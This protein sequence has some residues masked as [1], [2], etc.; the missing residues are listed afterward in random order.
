MNSY[1][2]L[3]SLIIGSSIA[4]PVGP[5]GVLCIRRTLAHGRISGFVSGLGAATADA[6]YGSI[7]AFGL[8]FISMLLINQGIWLRLVGGI[9]LLILGFKTFFSNPE[10]NPTQNNNLQP[11][12]SLISDY[13]TT[14]FLTLTNPLTIIS[15]AAIFTG[16][17]LN[18]DVSRSFL[19]ALLMVIGIFLGSCTWWFILSG[20]TGYFRKKMNTATMVWINR[21]S[22]MIISGFGIISLVTLIINKNV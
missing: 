7:A 19:D 12:N 10:N 4:A 21:L 8:T 11:G 6:I 16:L 22:G 3:K 18:L 20:F 17:G 1:L 15:F 5:I 9:F 2:F 14:L 13:V